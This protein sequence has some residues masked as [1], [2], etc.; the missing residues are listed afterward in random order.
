M[1]QTNDNKQKQGSHILTIVGYKMWVTLSRTPFQKHEPPIFLEL[2]LTKQDCLWSSLITNPQNTYEAVR[3]Y[4]MFVRG[5]GTYFRSNRNRQNIFILSGT[6]LRRHSSTGLDWINE[7]TCNWL[8]VQLESR[9]N[10][11]ILLYFG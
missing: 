7:M 10:E 8:Y 9:E 11:M 6:R 4:N 5:A 2:T 3:L 1:R